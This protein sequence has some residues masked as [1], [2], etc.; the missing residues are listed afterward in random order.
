MLKTTHSYHA[1]A[2][3][4]AIIIFMAEPNPAIVTTSLSKKYPGADSFALKDLSLKIMPGEVYG[5][6]GPNG[7]GKSTAIRTLMN[8]IQPTEGRGEI[9]G[10]D[11]V[12]ES[13]DIKQSVGYLS[14]EVALYPK[15]TGRQFLNYM[16]ELHP[17]KHT[18]YVNKLIERF[19]VNLKMKIRDLSKGNRQK[20]GLLQAFM[21]QPKVL[22]LDEPT[23][24]L[25]PLMQEEFFKILKEITRR[26]GCAFVSSHNLSEVQKMCD[27]VGFIREGKLI[28]EQNIAK[29]A[30]VAARTFDIVFIDKISKAEL[31]EVEG[32][33]V[34]L[35]SPKQATVSMRGDLSP[36]FKLLARHK[37]ASINQREINLEEEFMHFYQKGKP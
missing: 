17:P 1:E 12:K 35:T 37:V 27:R 29:V 5:F 8:F 20:I 30:E 4:A 14:G 34:K 24:G 6:L 18:S 25:D 21:H 3:K 31:N 32:A 15:M 22:I 28:S 7:A 36:M 19:Q 16:A 11:I 23:G 10:K 9:L 13:V 33:K 26:G 2:K